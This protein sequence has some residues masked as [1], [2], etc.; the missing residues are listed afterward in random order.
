MT[1][2]V[3]ANTNKQRGTLSV[4]V[5]DIFTVC[6]A[7]RRPTTLNGGLEISIAQ[8]TKNSGGSFDAIGK[9]CYYEDTIRIRSLTPTNSLALS[10]NE[11]VYLALSIDGSS[12]RTLRAY[13]ATGGTWV[14][15]HTAAYQS[16]DA[17]NYFLIGCIDTDTTIDEGQYRGW[18]V[19]N[20]VLTTGELDLERA[21]ETPVKTGCVANWKLKDDLTDSVN[22][23]TLSADDA[24]YSFSGNAE[25][26]WL[27]SGASAVAPLAAAYY[28]QMRG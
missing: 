8:F 21:S 26:P 19:F 13:S 25:S 23:Y 16:G 7:W 28:A 20:T 10:A 9:L 14:D 6:G 15:V 18:R 1:L 4:S 11:W 3:T 12:N 5:G 2:R 27:S 22:G 24:N 17:W